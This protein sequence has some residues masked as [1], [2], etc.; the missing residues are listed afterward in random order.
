[1][2]R[3]LGLGTIVKVDDDDSGSVFTTITLTVTANPPTRRRVRIDGVTLGDTLATDELG[4]EDKSDVSFRIYSEPNDT[5]HAMLRTLFG[6]KTQVLW[7]ITYASADVEQFD[8]VIVSIEPTEVTADGLIGEVI[9]LHRKAAI[10][11]S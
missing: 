4:I 1:M 2:A 11:Y 10:A 9:T 8:A 7:N 3:T 6:S 5:Q